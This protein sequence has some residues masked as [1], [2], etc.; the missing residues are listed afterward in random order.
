MALMLYFF[1]FLPFT[2]VWFPQ[3]F[4]L[5]YYWDPMLNYSCGATSIATLNNGTVIGTIGY[6]TVGNFL[7]LD[8][9]LGLLFCCSCMLL[10]SITNLLMMFNWISPIVKGALVP[11]FFIICINYLDALLYCSVV[12]NLGIMR[13]C[14]NNSTTSACL[15]PLVF[16]VYQVY[17]LWCPIDGLMYHPSTSWIPQVLRCCSFS[18][19]NTFISGGAGGV[20][21]KS[22]GPSITVCANIVG[23]LRQGF[24]IFKVV[25][26]CRMRQHQ[27]YTVNWVSVLYI[28][29]INLSF[30]ILMA[31]SA[32]L[33]RWMC[34]SNNW[35]LMSSWWLYVFSIA[36]ASLSSQYTRGT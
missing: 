15:S 16:G 25:V 17:H 20:F 9:L 24:N 22:N 23:F 19:T 6:A 33:T 36:D 8:F 12:D 10:N 7:G 32:A 4:F 2:S 27:R 13:C 28:T 35:Y 3:C 31:C 14:G 5:W 26:A 30:H 1:P 18:C 11:G 21:K 29:A 34:G